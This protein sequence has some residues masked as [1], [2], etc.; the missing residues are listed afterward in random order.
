MEL[1]G[2]S[3]YPVRT[4]EANAQAE[5]PVSQVVQ[6]LID[7]ASLHAENNGF[8]YRSLISEGRAWV[9]ARLAVEMVR[10]PR[11][12]ET[13]TIETWVE[14]YNKHFTTRNYKMTDQKGAVLGYGRSF[15]LVID[16]KSRESVDLTEYGAIA[17]YCQSMECPAAKP[18]R[19]DPLKS[20]PVDTYRVR[21]SDLD[22]NC[23]MTS[24]KYI[25]HLLD[26][27]PL[28]KFDRQ[29]IGR[30]EIH[31]MNEARYGEEVQLVCEDKGDDCYELEMRNTKGVPIC[32]CRT[33]FVR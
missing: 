11:I 6:Y 31:F 26:L 14:S 25:S 32:R 2:K 20:A 27:F 29:R 16:F 13:M 10:Y 23:H 1:T 22:V 21:V 12:D 5:L 4:Y 30:F 7:A 17:G 24:A 3:D 8:G 9:L 15:W 19:I 28:E 18:G 33:V